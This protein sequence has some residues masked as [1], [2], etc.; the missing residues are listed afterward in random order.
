M[1]YKK[2]IKDLIIDIQ[3]RF[4]EENSEYQEW[5][6]VDQEIINK[7]LSELA[8]PI[9]VFDNTSKNETE[10]IKE[11]LTITDKDTGEEILLVDI[12][13]MNKRVRGVLNSNDIFSV[14]R[15]VA[16]SNK[17]AHRFDDN[18][19]GLQEQI[20]NIKEKRLYDLVKVPLDDSNMKFNVESFSIDGINKLM[21]ALEDRNPKRGKIISVC[22]SLGIDITD[23]KSDEQELKKKFNELRYYRR[24]ILESYI[25]VLSDKAEIEKEFRRDL[26]WIKDQFIAIIGQLLINDDKYSQLD[27]EMIRCGDGEF[28]NMLAIDYPELSYYIELHMPNY[29]ADL[30]ITEFGV[31]EP[32][33]SSE[34][35]FERLGASA[36]YDREDAEIEAIKEIPQTN[37]RRR[38]I[39]RPKKNLNAAQKYSSSTKKIRTPEDINIMEDYLKYLSINEI[40][41]SKMRSDEKETNIEDRITADSIDEVLRQKDFKANQSTELRKEFMKDIKAFARRKVLAGSEFDKVFFMYAIGKSDNEFIKLMAYQKEISSRFKRKQ[42]NDDNINI[43]GMYQFIENETYK[44][45]KEINK[46]RKYGI[47]EKETGEGNDE[48]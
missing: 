27:Y 6:E 20:K 39:S 9:G 30:L 36:V 5:S 16:I 44:Y 13:S 3:R 34:R 17:C 8:S 22:K 45:E 38:I 33:D 46:Y 25:K 43:I 28:E 2:E 11:D 4:L 41:Y 19:N 47:K 18:Y 7:K 10:N 21:D 12:V 35:S 40:K 15:S 31:K 29:M 26:F 24:E 42:E 37:A 32:V 14:L 1:I 48:R 23:I